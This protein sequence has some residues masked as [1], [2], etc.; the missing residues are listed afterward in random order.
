M[1]RTLYTRG[2]LK[3]YKPA[4]IT[5]SVGNITVGGTGKTPIVIYLCKLFREKKVAVV[6]RGYAS[7]GKGVRIVSDGHKIL[8]TPA[9]CG[10][11]PYLIASSVP[12][13]IVAVGK[14]R[15]KVIQVVESEYK[16]DIIILDDAFSHLKVKRDVDIV[17]VD[18]EKGF[19]NG[20]LLP[21]GPLREPVSSIEYAD[22]IGIKGQH[23]S[24]ERILNIDK[25]KEKTFYFTYKFSSIKDIANDAPI[26]ID[27]LKDKKNLVLAGIAFPESFFDLICSIGIKPVKFISKPDH[28]KYDPRTLRKLV[29]EYKP[30][31]IIVTG[32]DAVKIK[33]IERDNKVMWVYVDIIVEE[34]GAQLTSFLTRKG[35]L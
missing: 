20:H 22:M 23:A 26:K 13:V 33:Y 29:E 17:L 10:D 4:A 2:L 14:N 6:S 3:S 34:H 18:G 15:T 19:G 32:K 16:P 27:V 24:G 8:S 35:F 5:I 30:D 1:R 25:L 7:D 21:A 9:A 31:V 11:E 12:D 28:V